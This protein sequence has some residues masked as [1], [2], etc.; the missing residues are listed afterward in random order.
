MDDVRDIVQA[1]VGELSP[2]EKRCA[3]VLLARYPAIGLGTAADWATA[4]GTSMPTVLRF[5]SRLGFGTY[6]EFQ[7]RLREESMRLAMSPFQ[8]ATRSREDAKA[9]GYEELIE[10]RVTVAGEVLRTVPAAEFDAV[11]RMLAR[12]PRRIHLTGGVFTTHLAALLAAQLGQLLSGVVHTLDPLARDLAKYLDLEADDVVIIFDFRRYEES[13]YKIAER[14][15]RRKARLVLFTDHEMSPTAE[16]AD[17]V[18]PVYV[19]GVPF[20]SHS[21]VLVLLESIVEGVFDALGAAAIERMA[22]W[23]QDVRLTRVPTRHPADPQTAPP[24]PL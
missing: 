15:K 10:R 12:Q 11:V 6:R 24:R 18:L 20:D 1:R 2:A 22:R 8:R 14:V 17:V 13:A 9:G 23:E 19:D 4:A 5:V 16:L 21:G 3:R 7:Q